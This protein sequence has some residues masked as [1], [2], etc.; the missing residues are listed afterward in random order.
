MASFRIGPSV[1]MFM[2]HYILRRSSYLTCITKR[3][4]VGEDGERGGGGG[5]KVGKGGSL[6]S[7]STILSSFKFLVE[8]NFV[9]KKKKILLI[10]ITVY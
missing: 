3:V 4:C 8:G 5:G 1:E 9:R 6:L 2:H 7:I 10:N